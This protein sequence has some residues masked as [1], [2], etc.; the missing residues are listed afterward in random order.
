V[1]AS[2]AHAYS[3]NV[4][5]TVPNNPPSGIVDMTDSAAV[6]R[7]GSG[8]H[9]AVMH[10]YPGGRRLQYFCQYKNSYGNV[11]AYVKADGYRAGWMW[12]A[13]LRNPPTY[14]RDTCY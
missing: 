6:T 5:G 13:H 12:T 8:S 3:P 9:C 10:T 1:P 2:P 11:W 14:Y 4:C 7:W